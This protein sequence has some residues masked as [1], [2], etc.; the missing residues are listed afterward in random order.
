MI[1]K[2]SPI[3]KY[4]LSLLLWFFMVACTSVSHPEKDNT[5]KPATKSW[6]LQAK[7][8]L[9]SAIEMIDDKNGFAISRGR[10]D[11]PGKVYKSI[12]VNSYCY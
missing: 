12:F 10:G 4:F 11:F 9:G 8:D 5:K 3:F 7:M 1:I 6:Y 2:S